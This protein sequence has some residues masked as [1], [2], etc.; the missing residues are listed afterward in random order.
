MDNNLGPESIQQIAQITQLQ[1]LS[2]CGNNLKTI[3]DLNP[4]KKLELIQLDLEGNDLTNEDDYRNKVFKLFPTLEILDN[5]DKDGNEILDDAD[6]DED[7]RNFNSVDDEDEDGE[8]DEEEDGDEEEED[9]YEE[10]D[11]DEDEGKNLVN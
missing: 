6:D 10:D 8:D 1:A 9:D 4:I 3:G 5:C 2:I 7:S 11:E